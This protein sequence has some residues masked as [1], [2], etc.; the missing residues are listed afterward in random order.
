[1]SPQPFTVSFT[2]G[3]GAQIFGLAIVLAFRRRNIPVG[4]DL[5]YFNQHPRLAK[6]G[7]GVSIWGWALDLFGMTQEAVSELATAEVSRQVPLLPDSPL[8]FIL[9]VESLSDP[10][11]QKSFPGVDTAT[12]G[13]ALGL[14]R[15]VTS[16]PY[17]AFHLRRGDYL[18]IGS[19]VVPEEYYLDLVPKLADIM[20]SAVVRS[21]S[22]LSEN[23][24][25]VFE[26]NFQ[27]VEFVEGP[28]YDSGQV[29]HLLRNAAVQVGS[30]GQF[31][32][33]AGILGRG[34]MLRPKVWAGTGSIY[35]EAFDTLSEKSFVS[36]NRGDSGR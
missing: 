35:D 4:V 12:V 33:T 27:R 15:L 30:N 34:L 25:S 17:V 26:A 14:N 11:I 5:S 18:N 20:K 6:E 36:F 21:D 22:S 23:F 24:H 31:S 28:A 13:R 1:M 9:G 19:H 32:L 8:K 3:L 10:E 29:H 7:G 16:E 2:G